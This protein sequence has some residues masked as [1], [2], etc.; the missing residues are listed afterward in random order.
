MVS[1]KEMSRDVYPLSLRG[2]EQGLGQL[3][4][5]WLFTSGTSS[6]LRVSLI[7]CSVNGMVLKKV[8]QCWPDML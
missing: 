8:E 7:P 5:P 3:K 6:L 2:T 4:P 1:P